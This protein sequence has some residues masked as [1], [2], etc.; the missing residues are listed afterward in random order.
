LENIAHFGLP[1]VVSI[2][3]FSTDSEEEL[4]Y[5]KQRCAELGVRAELCEGWAEGGAGCT[6]LAQAVVDTIAKGEA[7]FTPL[8]D[9]K[10]D[11]KSKVET[12]AKKIYGASSVSF[13]PKALADMKHIESLGLAHLPIC[14]AKTQK[15]FS[16]N[17][18]LIGRPTGFEL[19]VR[20][21]EIAAGAG[22]LIPITGN[23]MR[24]P[25]LPLAPS[26]M[27]IDIDDNGVISGLS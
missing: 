15:S 19:S 16:D 24:L 5:L 2:N 14:I 8:Y 10:L 7:N 1:A 26:A 20:E 23:I 18:A 9:W 21:F 25:G 11:I 27:H 17:E 3:R 13:Q 12:I 22:F 4:S 6:D